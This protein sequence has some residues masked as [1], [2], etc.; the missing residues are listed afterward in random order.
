MLDEVVWK[1]DK[2]PLNLGGCIFV[3]LRAA[4]VIQQQGYT[5]EKPFV[6]T[7]GFVLELGQLT[8]A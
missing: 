1:K 8:S 4:G 7:F 6:L 2:P 5:T 3:V